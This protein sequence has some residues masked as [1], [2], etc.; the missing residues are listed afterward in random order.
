MDGI[1]STES[2]SASFLHGKLQQSNTGRYGAGIYAKERVVELRFGVIVK[3]SGLG[4]NL[5]LDIFAGDKF[6]GGVLEKGQR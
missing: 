3:A 5:E 4:K 6:A 2:S 1:K